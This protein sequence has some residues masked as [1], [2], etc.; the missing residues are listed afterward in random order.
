MDIKGE[1]VSDISESEKEIIHKKS[2]EIIRD[3]N[4]KD[5]EKIIK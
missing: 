3:W 1:I 5:A 4:R 2:V